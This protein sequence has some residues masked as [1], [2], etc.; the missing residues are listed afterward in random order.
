MANYGYVFDGQRMGMQPIEDVSTTQNHPLGTRAFATDPT[1]NTGEFI[2]V[3]GC[4]NGARGAWVII[5]PDDWSTTAV[6][7]NGIGA[8][9]IMMSAL[10]ATTD[11]GW[12]QIYGLC[13]YG[14]CLTAFADDGRVFLTASVGYV[15]DTSVTGDLVNGAK[16]ASTSTA[17]NAAFE[18][19]YPWCN[20]AT[21]TLA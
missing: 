1:Y 19:A 11:F 7:A 15:D 14:L 21:S 9:A 3:P 8:L 10:D 6:S 2:Y 13:P 18:L 16:G 17:R 4:T 12:A 5:N 20:D